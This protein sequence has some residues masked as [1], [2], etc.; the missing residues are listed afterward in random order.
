MSVSF[1]ELRKIV[2]ASKEIN[3]KERPIFRLFVKLKKQRRRLS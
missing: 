2:R 1:S 3:P